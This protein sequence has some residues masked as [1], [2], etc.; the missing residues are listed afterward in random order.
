MK[1]PPRPEAHFSPTLYNRITVVLCR[2]GYVTAMQEVRVG[3]R[4]ADNIGVLSL[5]PLSNGFTS[6]G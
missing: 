5:T 2:L 6:P 1:G 4:Q 3:F